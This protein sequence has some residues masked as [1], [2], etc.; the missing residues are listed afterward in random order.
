[1]GI[2]L[3][4]NMY[5]EPGQIS[6]MEF[7][8][9][10]VKEFHP[11]GFHPCLFLL[12][13]FLIRLSVGATYKVTI[14]IYIYIYHRQRHVAVAIIPKRQLQSQST[15]IPSSICWPIKICSQ[16]ITALW[17]FK[18]CTHLSPLYTSLW[19]VSSIKA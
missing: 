6:K 2:V 16:I 7:F 5:W 14:Y 17:N 4:H 11:K 1:M 8:A 19:T 13:G 3:I 15:I 10:I 18:A 12:A 9:K